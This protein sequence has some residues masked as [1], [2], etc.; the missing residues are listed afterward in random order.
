MHTIKITPNLPFEYQ[1]TSGKFIRLPNRIE[2]IDS[3]ARIELNGNFFCPNWNALHY[4]F[5]PRTSGGKLSK[6]HDSTKKRTTKQTAVLLTQH[7]HAMDKKNM[8]PASECPAISFLMAE[9]EQCSRERKLFGISHVTF[10]ALSI[11][12]PGVTTQN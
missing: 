6:N 10:R 11:S 2:K 4:S 1:C 12:I 3:V 7:G 9:Y 5:I 8:K